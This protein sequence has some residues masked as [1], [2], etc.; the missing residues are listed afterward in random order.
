MPY[1]YTDQSGNEVKQCTKCGKVQPSSE[2]FSRSSARDGLNSQCKSC[3]TAAKWVSVA[4]NADYYAVQ[5]QEYYE[6]TR[7][8]K[9][10]KNK[11]YRMSHK[12]RTYHR[13]WKY[14]LK[15]DEYLEMEQKQKECCAICGIH[16]SKCRGGTLCIDHDHETLKVREL[17]C[18]HCNAGIGALKESEAIMESAIAY[19]RKHNCGNS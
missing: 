3:A 8:A 16:K 5:K 11:E 12:E 7:A 17:L 6:R 1:K 18:H 10:V 14:G 15:Q 9:R 2:F 13:L 19:V 4:K